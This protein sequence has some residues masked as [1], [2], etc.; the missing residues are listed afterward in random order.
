MYLSVGWFGYKLNKNLENSSQQLEKNIRMI[1]MCHK[2]AQIDSMSKATTNNIYITCYNDTAFFFN[3]H[4]SFQ[5]EHNFQDK[6]K[7][8]NYRMVKYYTKKAVFCGWWK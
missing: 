7:K 1:A 3:L 6:C 2:P 5:C 4:I 8:N